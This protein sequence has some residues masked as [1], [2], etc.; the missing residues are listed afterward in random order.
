MELYIVLFVMLN[1]DNN[2]IIGTSS[3]HG[4]GKK[5]INNYFKIIFISLTKELQSIGKITNIEVYNYKLPVF[6]YGFNTVLIAV[7]RKR[8][9]GD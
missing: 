3:F 2:V 9:G 4:I 6:M 5:E 7:F 8:C 1:W